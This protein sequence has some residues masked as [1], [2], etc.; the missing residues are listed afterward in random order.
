MALYNASAVGIKAVHSSLHVGGPAT[1]HL[2][3]E[4]FMSQ[5]KEMGA[6]VDFVSTH[7]YPTGPRGDGSGCPQGQ[8]WLPGEEFTHHQCWA[9]SS[10]AVASVRA[11]A[12]FLYMLLLLLVVLVVVTVPT[13]C[14][15]E[16]VMATRR[17]IPSSTPLLITEYS[18]MVG[19]GMAR[20][21]SGVSS[22]SS[23]RPGEPPFQHED[24]GAAAFVFRVVPELS[25]HLEA[26]SYW[27][28]SDSKQHPD[29]RTINCSSHT[30]DASNLDVSH[31]VFEEN[32]IPRTEFHPVGLP[33]GQ[34]HYGLMTLHGV[35]KPAWRG[36]Q[37]LNTHAGSHTVP[38]TVTHGP[39]QS[40]GGNQS[41]IAAT[42]TMNATMDGM[43]DTGKLS[44]VVGSARVFLSHWDG[45]HDAFAHATAVVSLEVMV[46]A[47]SNEASSETAEVFMIDNT[48]SANLLWQRSVLY[49][50]LRVTA[51]RC[52]SNIFA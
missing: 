44:M 8:N 41:V 16:H 46:S 7:N 1:E 26:L 36:F 42:T 18:V 9:I 23:T 33:Y 14:F 47:H 11:Q 39:G 19:E 3:T 20:T 13:D 52:H 15:Y 51:R 2:N 17:D 4:N 50:R 32:S 12:K 31:T 38:T 48:T 28:F 5:A 29:H 25:P 6:A 27:T 40:T 37:L 21:D 49:Q 45:T 30:A 10:T 34:P 43:A 35:P 24:P 22:L